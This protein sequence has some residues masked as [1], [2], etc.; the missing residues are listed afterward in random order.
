[1]CFLDKEQEL[2]KGMLPGGGQA[3]EAQASSAADYDPR[4]F[5]TSVDVPF[6]VRA[7]A[8]WW[9]FVLFLAV[10]LLSMIPSLTEFDLPPLIL[11]V[12]YPR[13]H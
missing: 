2:N 3:L 5:T 13:L 9:V 6:R 10:Q 12:R 8:L 7:T 4:R 1:M 11:Q